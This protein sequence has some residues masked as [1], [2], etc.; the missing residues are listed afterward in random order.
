MANKPAR[1]IL[2]CLFPVAAHAATFNISAGASIGTIQSTINSAAGSGGGNTVLFAAGNY[3]VSGQVNIPCPASPLTIT[4]PSTIYGQHGVPRSW[5][6]TPAAVITNTNTGEVLPFFVVPQGCSTAVSITYLEWNANHPFSGG[7]FFYSPGGTSNLTISYNYIHGFYEPYPTVYC[8]DSDGA[9]NWNATDNNAIAISLTSDQNSS[10][11]TNITIQYNRFGN[12]SSPGANDCQNKMIWI[13]GNVGGPPNGQGPVVFRGYDQNGGTCGVFAQST[14]ITNLNY[15]YNVLNNI[16]EGIKGVESPSYIMNN[17]N[18]DYNDFGVIHHSYIETQMFAPDNT[19]GWTMQWNDFHDP[20]APSF[21]NWILSQ[22]QNYNTNEFD[23]LIIT[24]NT[25]PAPPGCSGNCQNTGLANQGPPQIEWWGHAHASNNLFQ[26][27]NGCAF[28][29]YSTED[30]PNGRYISNNNIQNPNG[31]GQECQFT[32]TG[33]HTTIGV[34]SEGEQGQ[35]QAN[36]PPLSGNVFSSTV[37]VI[38]SSVPTLSP[39]GG[40]FSTSQVVTV[41]NTGNSGGTTP[42]G[43]MGTWCTLDGSTP[44]AQLGTSAYYSDGDTFTLTSTTTVK[45]LG[46]WGAIT[47]PAS[48]P[49]GFGYVPSSVVTAT[50]TGGGTPTTAAVV[51]APASENFTTSVSVALSSST[52][53]STIKYCLTGG[54]TPSTTYSSPLSISSTTTVTAFATA[55]GFLQSPNSSATYT[56]VAPGAAATPVFSPAGPLTFTNPISVTIATTT[57]GATIYYTTDGST[58]TTSSTVYGTPPIMVS[59]TQ[60]LNAIATASGF[61]TSPVG[62]A[63]YTFSLFLG[64]NLIDNTT[65]NTFPGNF[66]SLYA[67]TGSN[68]AGYDVNNCIVNQ[69]S[70]TV[71]PG[72]HTACVVNL[73]TGPTTIAANAICNG[74]YTNTSSTGA[75][76]V[77]SLGTCHLD[78]STAYVISSIT[79]DPLQP[80]GLG[81][82]DCGGQCSGGVP[83]VGIG[84]YASFY[85]GGTY[86]TY[87]NMATQMN[88]G[89]YQVTQY[90]TL[91]ATSVTSVVTPVISPNSGPFTGSLTV[92]MS[93][94]T[95]GASIYYT[96]DGSTPTSGSTLYTA[97]FSVSATTTVKAIGV[98]AGMTDSAVTSNTFA[99]STGSLSQVNLSW[100]SGLNFVTAVTSDTLIVTLVYS[101]TTQTALPRV[102]AVDARGSTL[103]SITSSNTNVATISQSNILSGVAGCAVAVPNDT[104]VTAVV[105]DSSSATH[106]VT[107]LE[108]CANSLTA[109]YR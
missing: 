80:S 48:Y 85:F 25:A 63:T 54:C 53:S 96:T 65:S 83:I 77:I 30:G 33:G 103:T 55:S 104:I 93:D 70:A 67:I 79:D 87:V 52:P 58:P 88:K 82:N 15:S 36:A 7:G 108:A 105:T 74:S 69:G 3:N 49:S 76:A 100:Q 81:F 60:T 13:G 72:S 11:D 6:G 71:T 51:F 37:S 18:Y 26:G 45:C 109:G 56:L 75:M 29:F 66:N 86:G 28:T 17:T 27:Y 50:F 101:D 42:R 94:V 68:S 59:S 12:P 62:S 73:A 47:Q 90:L 89:I 10:P 39:N 41:H 16:E 107:V 61:T 38:T 44:G 9:M 84:T 23:N 14:S 99:L 98:K 34:Q 40:S 19:P 46:M 31:A 97:P 35:T 5:T 64:N 95:A 21:A 57:P 92:S 8:C 4:G 22:A 106:M 32:D 91:T 20:Y 2:L 102:G 24:N 78:P 1:W 43:N